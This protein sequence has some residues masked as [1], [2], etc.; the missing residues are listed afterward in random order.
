MYVLCVFF[1]QFGS[2]I[3]IDTHFRL[4][5]LPTQHELLAFNMYVFIIFIETNQMLNY[6]FHLIFN[7][8]CSCNIILLLGKIVGGLW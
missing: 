8:L 3:L 5:N 6:I 2:S 7:V 4:N 1:N